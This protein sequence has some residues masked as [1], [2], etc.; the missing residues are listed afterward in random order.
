LVRGVT[1]N[2][3]LVRR[4]VELQQGDWP[5]SG[6]CSSD[7]WRHELGARADEL[8]V[9]STIHFEDRDWRI[10]GVFAAGGAAFESEVWCGSMNCS[11]P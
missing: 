7:D 3:L 8:A 10:S 11:R 5:K 4:R 1:Q 9:G 2:I 6:K